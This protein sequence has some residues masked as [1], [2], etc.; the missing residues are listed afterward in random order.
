MVSALPV[1]VESLIYFF[2]SGILVDADVADVAQEGEVDGIG[3]VFLVVGLITE[4]VD[5]F[6]YKFFLS[7][8]ISSSRVG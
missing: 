6:S 8:V 1:E 3:H 4:D 5:D 7:W 2:F